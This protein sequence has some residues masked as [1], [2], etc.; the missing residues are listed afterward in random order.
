[1]RTTRSSRLLFAPF[2]LAIVAWGAAPVW[3][4]QA[5]PER[6]ASSPAAN[7]QLTDVPTQVNVTFSVPLDASSNLKVVTECNV[8][9]DDGIVQV[10]ANRIEVG[11]SN[12]HRDLDDPTVGEYEVRYHAKSVVGVNG[13]SRSSFSFFAPLVCEMDHD[14]HDKDKE[15]GKHDKDKGHGKHDKDKGHGKHD[16]DKDHD[17][18]H[19]GSSDH[20][21]GSSDHG[22]GTDHASMD[23]AKDQG[24]HEKHEKAGPQ[25][26]AA[27]GGPRA[28]GPEGGPISADAQAAV[29]GLGL[30]LLVGVMGGWFLRTSA[31]K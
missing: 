31:P 27:A 18:A 7:E 16:K 15:H 6:V 10:V 30:A 26:L 9:V 8:R 19:S 25:D 17:G 4:G 20:G 14:K 3:A 29:M 13:E 23:H 5:A 12:K 2:L 22:S 11:I 24:K 21:S 1:M 28:A